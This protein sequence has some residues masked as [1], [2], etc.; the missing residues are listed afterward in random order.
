VAARLLGDGRLVAR[1]A[2]SSLDAGSWPRWRQTSSTSAWLTRLDLPEPET[3]VTDVSTPS[4]K[5]ASRSLRLLR[6]MPRSSSQPFG[7]RRARV[8]GSAAANR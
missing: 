5:R 8:R 4:G 2:S 6:V 7:S 1:L 3:P